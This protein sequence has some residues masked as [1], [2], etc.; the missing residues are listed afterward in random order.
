MGLLGTYDFDLL[1]GYKKV[2][3]GTT[4]I[5]TDQG[6]A[7][8]WEPDAAKI[9]FRIKAIEMARR[10]DIKTWVSIEPVIDPK[11]ALELIEKY[12]PIVDHWKIGKINYHPEI[13]AKV[14]W[15]R[16]RAEVESLLDSLGANYYLKKSLTDLPEPESQRE[17]VKKATKTSIQI[18]AKQMAKPESPWSGEM[19]L[20][21]FLATNVYC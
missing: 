13:E 20:R 2:S 15:I 6:D 12:H 19:I 3:F 16:F 7:K 5:F 8:K 4:I 11:Q 1:R 10:K 14:D 21:L 9:D 17:D 18:G